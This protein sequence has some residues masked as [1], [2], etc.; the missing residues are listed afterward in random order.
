MIFYGFKLSQEMFDTTQITKIG[1]FL[2]ANCGVM[3][4]DLRRLKEILEAL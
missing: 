4:G 2:K 3:D 1:V